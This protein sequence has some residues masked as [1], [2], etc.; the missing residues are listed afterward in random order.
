MI[1]LYFLVAVSNEMEEGVTNKRDAEC[2]QKQRTLAN[3]RVEQWTAIL[4]GALEKRLT[5]SSFRSGCRQAEISLTVHQP[6]SHS[7]KV[8]TGR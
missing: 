6:L 1:L 4:E 5:G 8:T 3:K 7:S 2:K